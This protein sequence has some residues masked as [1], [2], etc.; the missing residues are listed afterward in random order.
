MKQARIPGYIYLPLLVFLVISLVQ[1]ALG[2]SDLMGG[3]LLGDF[4]LL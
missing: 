3:D 2:F 4:L 1:T